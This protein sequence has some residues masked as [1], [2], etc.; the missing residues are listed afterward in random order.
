MKLF[1]FQSGENTRFVYQESQDKDPVIQSSEE[2]KQGTRDMLDDLKT[3]V[4]DNPD[5]A[6]EAG[7]EQVTDRTKKKKYKNKG[8]KEV[9][10]LRNDDGDEEFELGKYK[11]KDGK[12]KIKYYKQTTENAGDREN[13]KK[14][15]AKDITVNEGS[16]DEATVD[17]KAKYKN[18][19]TNDTD[20]IV[21]SS[22][23]GRGKRKYDGKEYKDRGEF[24]ENVAT[25]TMKQKTEDF[26]VK[27]EKFEKQ[28]NDLLINYTIKSG[29]TLS[30]IAALCINIESGK[31]LSTK[32]LYQANKEVIGENKH[33]ISIGKKI[34]IPTGYTFEKATLPEIQEANKEMWK[35]WRAEM[36]AYKDAAKEKGV[37]TTLD[38]TNDNG[39]ITIAQIKKATAKLDG[40]PKN[41]S[42]VKNDQEKAKAVYAK[43]KAE[44]NINDV[45]AIFPNPTITEAEI[46]AAEIMIP[47]VNKY[48]DTSDKLNPTD[49]VDRKGIKD[50][51]A[52]ID[53]AKALLYKTEK[54]KTDAK[55]KATKIK[56]YK[57]TVTTD[58]EKADAKT[59]AT[60]ANNAL[61]AKYEIIDVLTDTTIA[62]ARTDLKTTL[63]LITISNDLHTENTDDIPTTDTDSLQVKITAYET[64]LTEAKKLEQAKVNATKANNDLKIKYET[65]PTLNDTTIEG[66]RTDLKNALDLIKISNDLHTE[67]TDD[68]PTTDTDSLQV[69]IT[70]YET[71]L[72]E[73]EKATALAAIDELTDPT[74]TIP[75]IAKKIDKKNG[76]TE[77]QDKFN[78]KIEALNKALPYNPENMSVQVKTCTLF[79]ENNGS[80]LKKPKNVDTSNGWLEINSSINFELNNDDIKYLKQVPNLGIRTD[81]ADISFLSP[82]NNI[83]ELWLSNATKIP[84]TLQNLTELH[85][86]KASFLLSDFPNLEQF[87]EEILP[88][89]GNPKRATIAIVKG[90]IETIKPPSIEDQ[91]A[92]LINKLYR[93]IPELTTDNSNVDEVTTALQEGHIVINK[94]KIFNFKHPNN[95]LDYSDSELKKVE[96]TLNTHAE[97]AISIINNQT[98]TIPDIV[99]K[100]DEYFKNTDMQDKFN[101]KIEA[102]KAAKNSEDSEYDLSKM[103][104]Q[105]KTFAEF[106]DENGNLV[107]P[108]SITMTK[109]IILDEAL[110]DNDLKYLGKIPELRIKTSLSDIS[111]FA[112]LVNITEL[113][114]TYVENIPQ[115][116]VNLKNISWNRHASFELSDFLKLEKI[117]GVVLPSIGDPARNKIKIVNGK[118]VKE[119]TNTTQPTNAGK[120]K[121]IARIIG[122]SKGKSEMDI[123][124]EKIERLKLESGEV[125]IPGL[126]PQGIS[127]E[128]KRSLS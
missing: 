86:P 50:L 37:E 119:E 18:N 94:I 108:K 81:F 79:L 58:V 43:T 70:A 23:D 100:V 92:D 22:I 72:T 112:T 126:T 38:A 42:V 7:W 69:K 101:E 105:V 4:E 83:T 67:D 99:T 65:I 5:K 125:N 48:A 9:F 64:T 121:G 53:A 21:I 35:Q 60:N 71:T 57:E 76:N 49:L 46:K 117:E 128:F 24:D 74:A 103:S 56:T 91:K 10:V 102:L 45:A 123:F 6:K 93:D 40:I 78:K 33:K 82:L 68:I 32:V 59:A 66:A 25:G 14:I 11:D 8:T 44:E 51:Q 27:E 41:P 20:T 39:D 106:L 84:K 88:P 3:L 2:L 62:E 17:L 96:T 13:L 16:E 30:N 36:K 31:K 89:I 29:D 85:A 95:P 73:V 55:K 116:L 19:K 63:D 127:T 28:I 80:D 104:D 75:K 54:A 12:T 115:E 47:I 124:N 122:N 26:K 113:H 114:I 77:M 87:S 110:T 61:K 90:K 109:R 52:K 118:I 97:T 15:K 111:S 107:N 120:E 98:T 34:V 1:Q